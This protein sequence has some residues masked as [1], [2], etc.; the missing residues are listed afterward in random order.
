MAIVAMAILLSCGAGVNVGEVSKYTLTLLTDGNGTTSPSGSIQVSAGVPVNIRAY[1]N[2]EFGWSITF[3]QWNPISGTGFTIGDINS[4]VTT[5]TLSEEDVILQA[6]FDKGE[7]EFTQVTATPDNHQVTLQWDD[8]PLT[9]SYTLYYRDDGVTPG[10]GDDFIDDIES[11]YIMGEL[12]NGYLYSFRVV[13]HGS[14]GEEQW[15]D[16]VQ[17]IPL[18]PIT[19]APTA[20]GEYGQIRL[21]WNRLE[22]TGTNSF[23]VKRAAASDGTYVDISGVLNNQHTYTDVDVDKGQKYFYK[24]VPATQSSI[25]SACSCAETAYFPPN[26]AAVAGSTSI[27][28]RSTGVVVQGNYAYVTED[29]YNKPALY[30][31]DISNPR[32]PVVVDSSGY[33]CTSTDVAVSGSYAY[34]AAHSSGPKVMD[35]DPESDTFLQVVGDFAS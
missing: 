6:M 26:K 9:E 23:I 4:S 5:I 35:I 20:V 10:I 30:V 19:L 15:S 27:N 17:A 24:I 8:V 32:S 25:E 14:E 34:I 13:A 21:E 18:S 2:E 11:P 1:A 33:L 12:N 16:T 3:D 28:G 7:S 29:T 22:G 31:I